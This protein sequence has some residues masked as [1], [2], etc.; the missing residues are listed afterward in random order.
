MKTTDPRMNRQGAYLGDNLRNKID[1]LYREAEDLHKSQNTVEHLTND[2]DHLDHDSDISSCPGDAVS[3][4]QPSTDT[5]TKQSRKSRLHSLSE[6][7]KC[8]FSS[9]S[10]SHDIEEDAVQ[11]SAQTVEAHITG[12]SN[13]S[14]YTITSSG[15]RS[16]NQSL[17]EEKEGEDLDMVSVSYPG[18]L[19]IRHNSKGD[20]SSS[21][22]QTARPPSADMKA[23]G[24]VR[25]DDAGLQ[26]TEEAST[27]V[28]DAA[29]KER[30]A[31]TGAGPELPSM[32][33]YKRHRQ[34]TQLCPRPQTPSTEPDPWPVLRSIGKSPR[35]QPTSPPNSV[36]GTQPPLRKISSNSVGVQSRS[37]CST[38]SEWRKNLRK[39]DDVVL[40]SPSKIIPTG[41]PA[42]EWRQ[43]LT[44]AERNAPR[45]SHRSTLCES[46]NPTTSKPS[47]VHGGTSGRC[48]H[49]G[50][51]SHVMSTSNSNFGDPFT[52]PRVSLRSIENSL[53]WKRVQEDIER[54][55]G[56]YTAEES[57]TVK[58][59]PAFEEDEKEDGS[60]RRSSPRSSHSCNWRNRYEDL[61][62]EIVNS[63]AMLGPYE[64]G[65]IAMG[66]VAAP[67]NTSVADELGIEGLTIV[68][69]M[70]HKD[71]LVIKTDLNGREYKENEHQ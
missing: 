70:R 69:H 23:K 19:A 63:E 36:P 25:T 4:D 42:T 43:S 59:N 66:E 29:L 7:A 5:P 48:S 33:G 26:S 10:N 32:T 58:P 67:I 45:A 56:S 41:T 18:P 9:R 55:A 14:I 8:S 65:D 60:V 53:A 34:N 62:D 2:S 54:Q 39:T 3:R 40:G 35:Y 51:A 15:K 17:S 44:K 21:S 24:L 27:N 31:M 16:P 68:V 57:P 49:K 22:S 50:S 37:I 30:S 38:P 20:G 46:C 12:C 64:L 1:Q 6:D 13:H 28:T 11:S 61:R 52:E 71:D 47:T